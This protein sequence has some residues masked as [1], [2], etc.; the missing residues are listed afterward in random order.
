MH[1]QY[2][3]SDDYK[4]KQSKVPKEFD[5]DI[6]YNV[7]KKYD[8]NDITNKQKMI[9]DIG[10]PKSLMGENE[11]DKVTKCLSSRHTL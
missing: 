10:C 4:Y 8:D 11:W 7:Y 6:V 5:R 2:D 1:H 9:I 3:N